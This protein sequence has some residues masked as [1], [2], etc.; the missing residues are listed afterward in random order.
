MQI[1]FA[2]ASCGHQGITSASCSR[3]TAARLATRCARCSRHK[4]GVRAHEMRTRIFHL[5]LL[6]AVAYAT[7]WALMA[8]QYFAHK[9]FDVFFLLAFATFPATMAVEV[10]PRL[11]HASENSIL[12]IQMF[13]FLALGMIQYAFAGYVVALLVRKLHSG[14]TRGRML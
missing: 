11:F 10:L 4:R 13:L 7:L 6:L 5:P 2:V 1:G 3:P 8:W 12:L 14:R 9:N